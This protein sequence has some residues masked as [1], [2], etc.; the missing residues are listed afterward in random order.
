MANDNLNFFNKNGYLLI[1]DCFSD[2]EIENLRS[3]IKILSKNIKNTYL[4][5]S[6]CL[7]EKDI[8]K[9][10]FNKKL[11]NIYKE[12][13]QEDV[14][15]I[16]ELHVQINQFPKNNRLGWHYDGQSERNNTYLKS[17]NRKFFRVGIY[18]QENNDNYGGG[19]D[20]INN[21]LFKKIPFKIHNYF[22]RKIIYLFS[23]F[24][25]KS[26][27]SKKGSVVFFD[28]RLPHKG[29]YPKKNPLDENF[30]DK[31]TIYFQLGNKEHCEY[32]LKN[33]IKRTFNGYDNNN[34]AP[35]FL[36]YLKLKFP[37]EYP[38]E[39]VELLKLNKI[40]LLTSTEREAKF[41]KEFYSFYNNLK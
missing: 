13:I 41:F 5:T 32:F 19:I 23:L 40:N 11:L 14:Y 8:Y 25:S 24:F 26:I 35:Y 10:I 37:E 9:I 7:S 16:P 20:I 17:K 15:L 31:F 27:K 1:N 2:Q 22:E 6:L 28:S 38:K 3:K 12:I 33:N 39:F 34:V 30:K 4:L 29:T 36:D 21:K 18:L